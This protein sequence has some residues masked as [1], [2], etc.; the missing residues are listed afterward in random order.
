MLSFS[1]RI[2]YFWR[3]VD[4]YRGI[5]CFRHGEIARLAGD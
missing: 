1:W 3:N 2:C 4:A 5:D